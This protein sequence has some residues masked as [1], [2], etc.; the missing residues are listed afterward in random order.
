MES[1]HQRCSER[2][3]EGRELG[4]RRRRTGQSGDGYLAAELAKVLPYCYEIYVVR[5]AC[6][7]RVFLAFKG[8][9]RCL[10]AVRSRTPDRPARTD[11]S[12]TLTTSAGQM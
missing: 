12:E 6:V 3:A 2:T 9:A 11:G 1:S 10:V 5:L 7:G 4:S 8:E